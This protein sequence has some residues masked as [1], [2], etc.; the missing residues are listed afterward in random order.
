MLMYGGYER[1]A[2]CET[3]AESENESE[4]ES[5][6]RFELYFGIIRGSSGGMIHTHYLL[7]TIHLVGT[8]QLIT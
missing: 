2:D 7:L 6:R 3:K 1:R 4:N 8:S 5:T